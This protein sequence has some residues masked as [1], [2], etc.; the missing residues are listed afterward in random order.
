MYICICNAVTDSDIRAA[1]NDG[2]SNLKQLSEVT[3]CGNA[4]G[5]CKEIASQILQRDLIEKK[6]LQ[7]MLPVM[8][9]A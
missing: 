3:G 4:C 2:V 5:C 8:Q 6:T 7:F 1:V 9:L